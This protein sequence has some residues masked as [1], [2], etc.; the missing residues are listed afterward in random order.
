MYCAR[1]KLFFSL[2]KVTACL[3]NSVECDTSEWL[4]EVIGGGWESNTIC[5]QICLLGS[6]IRCLRCT[7]SN[8]YI[9]CY[10]PLGGRGMRVL[11]GREL[12]W[13][14]VTVVWLS[15]YSKCWMMK[16]GFSAPTDSSAYWLTHPW[17]DEGSAE[18]RINKTHIWD[19]LYWY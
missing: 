8:V 16:F 3:F 13:N 7:S 4:R 10:A 2:F 12:K 17:E 19:D 11:K 6:G 14:E 1:L 5:V 18:K 9:I 15:I